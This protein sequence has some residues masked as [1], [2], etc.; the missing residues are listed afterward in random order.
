MLDDRIVGEKNGLSIID[1][2]VL[3]D[4]IINEQWPQCKLNEQIDFPIVFSRK[5]L[6]G[7]QCS[8]WRTMELKDYSFRWEN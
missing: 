6:R 2:Q 8:C 5:G 7:C 4:W 3:S 1:I